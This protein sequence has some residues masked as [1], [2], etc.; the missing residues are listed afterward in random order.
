[1]NFGRLSNTRTSHHITDA[2]ELLGG[3]TNHKGA[4]RR[5]GVGS[6]FSTHEVALTRCHWQVCNF[7]HLKNLAA[8][9]LEHLATVIAL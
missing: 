9:N 3:L 5:T 4:Q 7:C 1:M 6:Y 8:M 2:S